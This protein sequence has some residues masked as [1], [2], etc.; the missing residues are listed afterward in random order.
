MNDIID[1]Y[2]QP[3]IEEDTEH[4]IEFDINPMPLAFGDLEMIKSVWANLIENAVKFT[5]KE[6][7]AK[8]AIGADETEKDITF[9]IKDNGGGI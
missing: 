2:I 6:D 8:I 4:R 1:D 9:Y 7:V 3:I 5:R